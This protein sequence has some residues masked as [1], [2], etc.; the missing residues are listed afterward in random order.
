M[1]EFERHLRQA[2]RAYGDTAVRRVD[3]S[4]IAESA[5]RRAAEPPMAVRPLRIS[6]LTL[7]VALLIL[8]ALAAT[9][10]SRLPRPPDLL[11]TILDRGSL[12]VGVDPEA[13]EPIAPPPGAADPAGGDVRLARQLAERLGVDLVL[14]PIIRADQSSGGWNGRLDVVIDELVVTSGLEGRLVL[15]RPYRF[16]PYGL[17]VPV[18]SGVNRVPDLVRPRA[19]RGGR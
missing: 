15:G 12:R 9:A 4:R 3:P 11:S 18:G 1:A 6:W 5:E 14:V 19:L 13:L 10:G 2:I 17:A 7:V 16:L 8:A